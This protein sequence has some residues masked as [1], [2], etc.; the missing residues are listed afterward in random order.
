MNK[1]YQENKHFVHFFRHQNHTTCV[2]IKQI[3]L[4]QTKHHNYCRFNFKISDAW[5]LK[6]SRT[7]NNVWNNKYEICYSM[8]YPR[9]KLTVHDSWC[10]YGHVDAHPF[11]VRLYCKVLTVSR[12]YKHWPQVAASCTAWINT[13]CSFSSAPIGSTEGTK[14]AETVVM[15]LRFP[16]N[17]LVVT[18]TPNKI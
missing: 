5:V 1:V 2:L 11:R 13:A 9:L 16:T 17:I 12:G 6:L 8:W 7:V 3:F 10:L 15:E 18:E 14:T 4:C